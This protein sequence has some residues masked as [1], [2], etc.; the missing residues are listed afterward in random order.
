MR[1]YYFIPTKVRVEILPFIQLLYLS[2]LAVILLS[3]L[4][5]KTDVRIVKEKLRAVL[6]NLPGAETLSHSSSCCADSQS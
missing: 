4:F 5:L 2:K 3:I 6:P 1:I